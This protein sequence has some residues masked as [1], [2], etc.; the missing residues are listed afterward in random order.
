MTPERL[1]EHA[2]R[3]REACQVERKLARLEV[4]VEHGHDNLVPF[5]ERLAE[6]LASALGGAA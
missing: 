1:L 2:E 6:R 5:R 4:K 3:V